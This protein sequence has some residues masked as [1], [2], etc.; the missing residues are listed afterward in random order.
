[1]PLNL[2][3]AE[4]PKDFDPLP[5]GTT[6]KLRCEAMPAELKSP[7]NGSGNDYAEG[8]FVVVSQPYSGRK[9]FK[10]LT[11]AGS[12]QA[13]KISESFLR[14]LVDSAHGFRHDDDSAEAIEARSIECQSEVVGLEF[15]ARVS[16]KEE[17]YTDA[18]GAQC[19]SIKNDISPIAV[20]HSA[21][22]SAMEGTTVIGTLA[23]AKAKKNAAVPG[24]SYHASDVTNGGAQQDLGD[25]VPF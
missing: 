12:E 9:F 2:N 25:E 22:E 11:L 7:K 14:G 17:T 1:M 21:Y 3:N 10:N 6:L 8:V 15:A 5:N 13:V 20:T 24:Q 23:P 18:S 4:Q 16:A 19:T